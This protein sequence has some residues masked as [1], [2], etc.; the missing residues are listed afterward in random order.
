MYYLNVVAHID[1]AHYLRGYAGKCANLHGH[2]WN[3]KVT[4]RKADLDELGMV[5]DFV[6]VKELTST[7]S[8]RF[9]HRCLNDRP[10]FE[11][12]NPTAENLARELY[13]ISKAFYPEIIYQVEV[14]E[15]P[16]YSAV[17]KE[18]SN[19]AAT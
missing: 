6:N 7:I 17:Y 10:P 14:W 13:Q 3:Y 16:E 9:D 8:D 15:S 19:G 2:R 5:E 11:I 18:E 4:L 12:L 1:S